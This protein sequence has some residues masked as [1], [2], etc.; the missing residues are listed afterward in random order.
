M[1]TSCYA[2]SE[3]YNLGMLL[4]KIYLAEKDIL[5]FSG[6]SRSESNPHYL[7]FNCPVNIN[8]TVIQGLEFH[9]GCLENRPDEGVSF[10]LRFSKASSSSYTPLERIDWRPRDGGHSNKRQ[11]PEGLPGR[12]PGSHIHSFHLNYVS[13][14]DRMRKPL[15]L[16]E[17]YNPEAENFIELRKYVGKRFNISNISVVTEPEWSLSLFDGK[18]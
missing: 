3:S 10:D 17:E 8:D 4:R 7:W 15:R 13:E 18:E 2:E 14:E 1:I 12:I 6:W 11:R 16:A 9:G 5:G